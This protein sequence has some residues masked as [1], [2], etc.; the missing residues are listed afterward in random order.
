M[1]IKKLYAVGGL[2]I[3]FFLGVPFFAFAQLPNLP[4]GPSPDQLDS[5]PAVISYIYNFAFWIVGIAVFFSVLRGGFIIFF[6]AAGSASKVAEGKKIITNAI[7]GLV[8]LVAS[9]L[10]LNVINP[11]LVKNTFDF[12]SSLQS[13][14][15]NS[16]PSISTFVPGGDPLPG[17]DVDVGSCPAVARHPES[18]TGGRCWVSECDKYQ[19][20]IVRYSRGVATP[21]LLRAIMWNETV[22]GLDAKT[23]GA[24]ALGLMQFL[25][26][27]AVNVSKSSAGRACVGRSFSSTAEASAWLKDRNNFGKQICLAAVYIDVN[28][29]KL[30]GNIGGIKVRHLAAGYNSGEGNC[31]KSDPS[32]FSCDNIQRR[33]Y[34]GIRETSQYMSGAL[35]CVNHL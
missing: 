5:I 35:Y 32:R 14:G 20:D 7:I 24:G 26:T 3:A 10:I 15:N 4:T 25:A 34:E 30:C 21:A 9:W 11:D 12:G 2:F 16:V 28:I 23:S 18:L 29:N 27:T 6:G 33:P 19:A 22:C 8:L 17:G 13:I 31:I 1:K